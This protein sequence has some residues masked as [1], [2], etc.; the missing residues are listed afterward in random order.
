MLKAE[1]AQFQDTEKNNVNLH[2]KQKL[3][4]HLA[5]VNHTGTKVFLGNDTVDKSLHQFLTGKKRNHKLPPL[6][7]CLG[8]EA[9]S[10][11]GNVEILVDQYASIS[12]TPETNTMSQEEM[13]QL[14]LIPESAI[15]VFRDW[16][17]RETISCSDVKN[18]LRKMNPRTSPGEDGIKLVIYKSFKD[19]LVPLMA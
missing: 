13:L 10:M 3:Q 11:Q 17:D 14:I 8:R 19:I 1:I 12:Q 9:K 2:A 7:N 18:A 4:N 6:R 16:E 15:R 5:S